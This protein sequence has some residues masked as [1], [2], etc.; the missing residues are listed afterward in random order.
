LRR[1]VDRIGRAGS[2]HILEQSEHIT[3]RLYVGDAAPRE[4]NVQPALSPPEYE[5]PR[6]QR[7]HSGGG[8]GLGAAPAADNLRCLADSGGRR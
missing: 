8:S 6:Q 1:T 5:G 3:G 7:V 4:R 2:A